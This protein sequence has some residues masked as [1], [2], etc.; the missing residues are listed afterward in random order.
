MSNFAP[1]LA[2]QA[3]A[4]LSTLNYPVLVSTK[5]DGIRCI[6]DQGRACSRNLIDLPN[7]YVQELFGDSRFDGLDGELILGDPREPGAY[8]RTQSLVMS[9]EAPIPNPKSYPLV[10]H[11]FD[12]VSLS[13]FTPFF[14]RYA[15]LSKRITKSS[16]I[17]KI[18]PHCHA[19]SQAALELIDEF[20]VGDG[21]E[22]TMI[23]DPDG[24]YKYGRSTTKQGWLLK[25]KRVEHGEAEI[26]GLT[27][28]MHNDNDE[29]TGGLAQRRS[30]KKAG[31]LG[32]NVL[33]SMQVRDLKTKIEFSV[34]TGFSADERAKLWQIRALLIG[35]IIRYKHIPYGVKTKPRNPVFDGFR[36]KIDL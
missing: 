23:R 33:G 29:R 30:S 17:I 28:L 24:P 18:V 20:N 26:L 35:E 27:E 5:L 11:V 32:M 8:N 10:F 16:K 7:R 31:K 3:P 6:I 12:D 4:D 25:L 21:Y 9:D 22:G 13:P 2:G 34:G 14:Q 36:S 1:M 19:I 15:S